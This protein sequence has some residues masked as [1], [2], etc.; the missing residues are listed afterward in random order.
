[1]SATVRHALQRQAIDVLLKAG[2]S[3]IEPAKRLATCAAV[4]DDVAV[5]TLIAAARAVSTSNP[6]VAADLS[7][8]AADLTTPTDGMRPS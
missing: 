6:E 5:S 1:V 2:M 8:R 7:R 4:G 3:P